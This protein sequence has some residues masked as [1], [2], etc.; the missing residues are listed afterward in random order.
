MKQAPLPPPNLVA[1]KKRNTCVGATAAIF[2]SAELREQ[3]QGFK[4]HKTLLNSYGSQ[5]IPCR[6]SAG[7]LF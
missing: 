1:P 6:P 5:N 7:I 2:S 3:W 4:Q